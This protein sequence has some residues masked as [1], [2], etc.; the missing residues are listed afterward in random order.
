MTKRTA[1]YSLTL[2]CALTMSIWNSPQALATEVS[3]KVGDQALSF[4]YAQP[5]IEDGRTLTPLRDLLVA[6][7][8][9]DDNDHIQWNPDKQSVTVIQKD[10]QIEL[11]AGNNILYKNGQK[12]AELDVPPKLVNERMFIPARAIAEALGHKVIYEAPTRTV[13]INPGTIKYTDLNKLTSVVQDTLKK[14]N[15]KEANELSVEMKESLDYLLLIDKQQLAGA[16]FD[17]YA[18]ERTAVL[19]FI[20]KYMHGDLIVLIEKAVDPASPASY[21]TSM[22]DII[23]ALPADSV[24][25]QLAN[26]LTANPNEQVRNAISFYLYKFPN[27]KSLKILEDLLTNE[28]SDKV[29]INAAASY[30]SIGRTMPSTYVASLYNSYMIASEKQREKYKPYLLLNVRNHNSTKELWNTLLK[31]KSD[32]RI[33]LE[34]QTAEELLKLK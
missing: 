13:L 12:F 11:T 3:M 32:S 31:E 10:I 29:F 4:H 1:V 16:L 14:I 2:A 5:F 24:V 30:Q 26:I 20:Q 6:L 18:L 8:V 33:E 19:D 23:T 27:S 21:G 9:P 25:D 22:T 15:G 28:Q 34:K 17:S 7:G